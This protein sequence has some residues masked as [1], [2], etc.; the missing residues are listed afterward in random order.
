MRHATRD[1]SSTRQIQSMSTCTTMYQLQPCRFV[2]ERGALLISSSKIIP[3]LQRQFVPL[4]T[5]LT[6]QPWYIRHDQLASYVQSYARHHGIDDPKV[7]SFDTR[8]EHV[9]KQVSGEWRL[10]LRKVEETSRDEVQETLWSEVRSRQHSP[11][12]MA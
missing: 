6:V 1:S 10:N 7:A 9:G 12:L 4:L 8:V 3:I 2:H 11:H 5:R